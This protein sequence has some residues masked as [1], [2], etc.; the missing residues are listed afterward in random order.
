M[1]EVALVDS[2]SPISCP[3]FTLAPTW[4]SWKRTIS[5]NASWA[6][7]LIPMT[8]CLPSTLRWQ[9]GD[10]DVV[11][12]VPSE[13]EQLLR[14]GRQGHLRARD[15]LWMHF[16]RHLQSRIGG[17]QR[18]Q[19][20]VHHFGM[21]ALFPSRPAPELRRVGEGLVLALSQPEPSG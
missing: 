17:P 9:A 6:W 12:P 11:V 16:Q 14:V 21:C 5:P 18:S 7:S 1:E 3:A 4:G 10:G 2:T 20:A 8:A 15:R 13:I 19:H